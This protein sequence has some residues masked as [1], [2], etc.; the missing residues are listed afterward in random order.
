MMSRSQSQSQSRVPLVMTV[1]VSLLAFLIINTPSVKLI[2]RSELINVAAVC[3][4][5]GAGLYKV[6]VMSDGSLR[7]GR[8]RVWFLALFAAM[9][10]ILLFYGSLGP[11]SQ[12]SMRLLLQYAG[13]FGAVVG[14][15]LFVTRSAEI[16]LF[17]IWQ[18][19]WAAALAIAQLSGGIELDR[20]QNQNYLTLGVPL[21]AGLVSVFGHMLITRRLWVKL[22]LLAPAA[23]V[24]VALTTLFGR[25]P[26]LFSTGTI[27]LFWVLHIVRN[28]SP[29]AKAGQLALMLSAGTVVYQI[30]RSNVSDYWLTRFA[31]LQNVGDESRV[32]IYRE[33]LKMV[34]EQPFGYGMNAADTYI[35]IYPHN[36]FLET[37][38]SGGILSLVALLGLLVLFVYAAGR[39]LSHKAYLMPCCMLAC[40]LF[41]TWNVSFNLTAAYT[42][43]GAIALCIVALE[44]IQ[45]EQGGERHE[46]IG[47]PA[48]A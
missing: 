2:Y 39:S 27:M 13:V 9:W 33:A 26:I 6:L 23:L 8:L 16:R 22:T 40:Y 47:R 28:G 37:M 42:P 25:A 35:G 10:T 3:L 48:D 31:R 24:T 12:A 19:V 45:R 21:A 29:F 5:W 46:R 36:I 30:I 7:F 20:S 14:L 43:I 32:A 18:I 44:L 34:R 41:L 38:I 4:L 11:E 15:L 17:L 1:A